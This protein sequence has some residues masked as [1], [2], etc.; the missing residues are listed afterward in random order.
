[1]T[2][3]YTTGTGRTGQSGQLGLP[4]TGVTELSR[5]VE[6]AVSSIRELLAPQL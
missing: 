1:M 6:D 2:P 4:R 5:T 3:E